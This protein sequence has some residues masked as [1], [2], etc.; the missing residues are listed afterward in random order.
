MVEYLKIKNRT[1]IVKDP[2]S[3]AILSVDRKEAD[4]YLAKKKAL[5]ESRKAN[6]GVSELQQKVDALISDIEEIKNL[7]KGILK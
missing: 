2:R 6:D 4:D 3:G 5:A 7:L 1:D